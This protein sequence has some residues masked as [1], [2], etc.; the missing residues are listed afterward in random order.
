MKPRADK[1]AG[2]ESCPVF[3]FALLHF[4]P[5]KNPI[6]GGCFCIQRRGET[7]NGEKEK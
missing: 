5:P 3:L 4:T 7:R 2:S 6:F 1:G